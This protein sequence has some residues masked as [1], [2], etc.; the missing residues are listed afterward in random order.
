M[1]QSPARHLKV[2]TVLELSDKTYLCT[3]SASEKNKLILHVL[4]AHLVLLLV[5]ILF[6]IYRFIFVFYSMGPLTCE[7]KQLRKLILK[8]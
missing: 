3:K 2:Q 8:C 5:K 4:Q 1:S 6:H 7:I